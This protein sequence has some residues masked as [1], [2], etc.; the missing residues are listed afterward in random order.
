MSEHEQAT[1][2]WVGGLTAGPAPT[3]ERTL[4][5]HASG[6]IAELHPHLKR[7][8]V[9]RQMTEALLDED[10]P[11]KAWGRS[12]EPVLLKWA[13]LKLLGE[14]GPVSRLS[15]PMKTRGTKIPFLHAAPDAV[16]EGNSTHPRGLV[17]AKHV[18]GYRARYWGKSETD[19]VPEY[20]NIQ[21]TLYMGL[22]D[23]SVSYVVASIGGRAPELWA[24]P[25][26]PTSFDAICAMDFAFMKRHVDPRVPPEPD[27][28]E[29][30]K[31]W[32]SDTFKMR[33]PELLKVAT[34]DEMYACVDAYR[35]A[36]HAFDLADMEHEKAKQALQSRIGEYEGLD[37]TESGERITWRAN[38]KPSS[39][40]KVVRVLR[41]P[42]S[43]KLKEED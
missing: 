28:S 5:G 7:I 22:M 4:G 20:A 24:V 16:F 11:E 1:Q 10:T 13:E 32:I 15:F 31:R 14:P 18:G 3:A 19:R 35:T 8:T 21:E 39:T 27:G 34:A 6:A 23:E 2:A 36:R 17:S 41:V 33:K 38:A 40:G 26:N 30:Y 29:Q 43:F 42:A 9:Y 12:V 25:F 37:L